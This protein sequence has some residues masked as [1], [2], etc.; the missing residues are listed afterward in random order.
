MPATQLSLPSGTRKPTDRWSAGR[1]ASSSRATGSP[2]GSTV[3][4]RKIA[5]VVGG[6]STGCGTASRP[7]SPPGTCRVIS[8]PLPRPS[9]LRRTACQAARLRELVEFLG[10]GWNVRRTRANGLESP[11]GGG[12]KVR[13]WTATLSTRSVIWP[14]APG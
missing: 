10:R 8:T 11:L 4:T 3:T 12:A 6:L 2:P 5:V 13:A 14:G 9:R 1:S 7:G